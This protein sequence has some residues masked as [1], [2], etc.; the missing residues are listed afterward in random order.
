MLA[1]VLVAT[2]S[3]VVALEQSYSAT[4]EYATGL[5][6]Q[7]RLLDFLAQDLRRATVPPVMDNDNQGVQITV[8]NY[9]RFNASDPQHLFPIPNDAQVNSTGTPAVYFDPAN[10]SVVT[11]RGSLSCRART[12]TARTSLPGR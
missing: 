7:M 12:T 3:G 11:I 4:E 8:P 10:P 5:A 2:L 6:D 1:V 9:Y